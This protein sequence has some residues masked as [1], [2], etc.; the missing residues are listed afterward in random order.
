M[1]GRTQV[2]FNTIVEELQAE[3]VSEFMVGEM[4]SVICICAEPDSPFSV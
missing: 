2:G 3:C 1:I 4:I